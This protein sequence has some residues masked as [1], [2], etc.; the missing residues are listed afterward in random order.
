M[1]KFL[2]VPEEDLFFFWCGSV[3]GTDLVWKAGGEHFFSSTL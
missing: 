3:H 2:L 1:N